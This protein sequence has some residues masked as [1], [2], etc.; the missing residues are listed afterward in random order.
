L[1]GTGGSLTA[2]LPGC[3]ILSARI[4]GRAAQRI[5]EPNKNWKFSLADVEERKFWRRYMSAYEEC[6][7][8]TSARE[9][10]WHVVPADDKENARLIVS[11]IILDTLNRMALYLAR[12]LNVPPASLPGESGEG[13]DD[14]PAEAK[15]IRAALL[16]TFDRQQQIGA[17]SQLEVS[18]NVLRE[19]GAEIVPSHLLLN[20]IDRVSEAD[21]ATLRAK[22][23]DAILLSAKSP[24][25]VAAL[26]ETIIA[27]FEAAMVEDQFV[28]PYAKQG[29]LGHL[30]A[31]VR[32]VSESPRPTT[33]P[34]GS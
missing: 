11:Q 15:E 19:I 6:L 22:Y 18:R 27:F 17:E 23:P 9:A 20:K 32:V 29:L 7:S 12:Y 5:D 16:D 31:N 26:R 1:T 21:R 33:A 10:P 8:A 25:D 4:E 34:A 2:G 14:L 13:L 30:Y 24:E 28:L 3:E